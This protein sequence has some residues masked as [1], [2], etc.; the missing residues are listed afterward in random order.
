[1]ELLQKTNDIGVDV[2]KEGGNAV[3][4]AIATTFSIGAVNM[5][6]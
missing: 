2:L 3:D 4:A 6:S 1:M 5:F